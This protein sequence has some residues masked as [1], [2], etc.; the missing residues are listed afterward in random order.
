MLDLSKVPPGFLDPIARVVDAA[1]GAGEALAAAEIMVVGA[2]SRD[3]LHAALGH[4][5]E[6]TATRDVDLALALTSWSAYRSLIQSFSR[7]GD[8]G[9]RY[10]IA[11]IAVDLLPFGEVEDPAGS[12][13]PPPRGKP[14]SVWAFR[15]VFAASLPLDLAAETSVRVP[16]VAGYAATKVV[17]WLDRSSWL[18]TKEAE[19]LALVLYWYS[20]DPDVHDRLYETEPGNAIL[21]AEGIDISLAAAHLLGTDVRDLIG[22]HRGVELGARWPGDA[23]LLAR[24]L[25]LRGGPHWPARDD[26]RRRALV[27]ALTRGLSRAG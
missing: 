15:E 4:Q 17:A 27:D 6:T 8:S 10:R 12:V 24:S 20:E 23:D 13:D 18:E 25:E 22:P 3:V 14:L 19:D 5:F 16:S 21:I 2:W 11:D 7:V 1:L 9:I 26:S